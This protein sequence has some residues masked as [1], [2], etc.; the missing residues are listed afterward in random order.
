MTNNINIKLLNSLVS[1]SIQVF[2]EI[3][4]QHKD[5][6]VL[7]LYHMGGFDGVFPM[8]NMLSN[9]P[10]KNKEEISQ[11]EMNE[12]CDAMWAPTSYPMLEMYSDRLPKS[13]SILARM[14]NS[15]QASQWDCALN[16][17]VMAMKVVAENSYFAQMDNA[18][19]FYV[20]TYD[21]AW[22]ERTP[23]IKAI[24]PEKIA[25]KVLPDFMFM[26]QLQSQWEAEAWQDEFGSSE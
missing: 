7:G 5:V 23:R 6:Y 20:A 10:V 25:A 18:P 22:C 19:V 9:V 24:N 11:D 4:A 13:E 3:I 17:M 21:E 1:E 12:Y 15:S 26:E 16:T 14:A 2:R 8:F